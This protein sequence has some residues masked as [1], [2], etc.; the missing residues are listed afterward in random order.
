[1]NW[2][3]YVAMSLIK[4]LVVGSLVLLSAIALPLILL[5][6]SLGM[7]LSFLRDHESKLYNYKFSSMLFD[8]ISLNNF[9]TIWF[10]LVLKLITHFQHI[11][12][13]RNKSSY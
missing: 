6:L 9:K 13:P 8:H 4:L 5:L 2:I 3:I 10:F 11:L 7:S 1:M 12:H